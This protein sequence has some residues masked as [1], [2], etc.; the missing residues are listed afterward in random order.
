M[1]Y[2]AG[3]D[4]AGRGP[5]IGPLVIAGVLFRQSQIEDLITLGV[6]DSKMLS[7]T[8][9]NTLATEILERAMNYQI[10]IA[11]PREIDEI[12]L[13]G[14]KFRKL[15]WLEAKLMA[16]VLRKLKPDIAYV[17]ASDIVEKRFGTQI[18]EL[19]PFK[20]ELISEH[21]ADIKYPIVSAASIIAKTHRDSIISKLHKLY[22][23]F[24]SG[25]CSDKRTIKF[26]S[27]WIEKHSSRE[28][29]WF[30]RK[31]WRTITRLTEAPKQTAISSY[32]TKSD[33]ELLPLDERND[34]APNR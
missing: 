5:V 33:I 23:D 12:V 26:L 20:L 19:L 4:D 25:Y 28:L 11:C 10:A 18:S 34:T 2:I 21:R 1:P 6:K 14:K 24:G 13:T 8:R 16:K 32:I 15:N 29:P 3:V 31:S 9:R 17:D 22:G 30:V 7:P 27:N